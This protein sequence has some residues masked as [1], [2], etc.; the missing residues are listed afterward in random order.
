MDNLF[1]A[2]A[3][4]NRRKIIQLLKKKDMSVSDLLEHFTFTQASLSHHLDI[5]KRA[6]LV[7]TERQGQFIIYSLN[8][9]VFEDVASM[10][11]NLFKYDKRDK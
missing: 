2:L 6:D 7:L 5:L 10:F 1:K 11:L 9:S 4:A 8:T 3:D